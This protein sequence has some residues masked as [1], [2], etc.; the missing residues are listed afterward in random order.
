MSI[1]ETKKNF[2]QHFNLWNYF[3]K[4]AIEGKLTVLR[5]SKKLPL[6]FVDDCMIYTVLCLFPVCS[7]RSASLFVLSVC[8]TVF[9]RKLYSVTEL[10]ASAKM[11]FV[12][13]TIMVCECLCTYLCSGELV[14]CQYCSKHDVPSTTYCS[15]SCVVVFLFF[16]FFL[17]SPSSSIISFVNAHVTLIV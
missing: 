3:C 15:C 9:L 7:I 17:F 8:S 10:A 16:F 1:F 6:E 14:Y 4:L 13:V 11:S 2:A 12:V 5:I